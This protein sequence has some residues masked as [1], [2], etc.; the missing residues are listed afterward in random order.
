[1]EDESKSGRSWDCGRSKSGG[2]SKCPDQW[3]NVPVFHTSI[4]IES[5]KLTR[6]FEKPRWL[7]YVYTHVHIVS[8]TFLQ[9][10]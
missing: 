1:M 9:E 10:V 3:E 7:K 5:S 8:A 2:R 6:P 4:F